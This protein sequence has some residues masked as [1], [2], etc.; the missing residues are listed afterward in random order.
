MESCPSGLRCS[1]G[2]AVS[3]KVDRRFE[4]ATLRQVRLYSNAEYN[5]FY[6]CYKGIAG[7]VI[8]R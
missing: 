4:S 8:N 1:P 7:F 2:K 5:L 3:V 6:F